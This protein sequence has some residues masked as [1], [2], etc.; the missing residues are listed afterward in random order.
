MLSD[1]FVVEALLNLSHGTVDQTTNDETIGASESQS[2]PEKSTPQVPPS[3]TVSSS[4]NMQMRRAIEIVQRYHMRGKVLPHQSA[5]RQNDPVLEQE[6][7]DAQKLSK[8]RQSVKAN[9][10]MECS[11]AVRDFLDREIVGWRDDVNS[12]KGMNRA[13][14]MQKARE[15]VERYHQRGNELPRKLA[16]RRHP[17]REQEYKDAQKLTKWKQTLKGNGNSKYNCPDEIRDYLDKEMP[18]WRDEVREKNCFPMQFAKDIVRRYHERGGVLPR[19]KIDHRK[20][21]EVTQ[22]SSDGNGT[23]TTTVYRQAT[24]EESQQEYKDARKLHKWRQTLK[25]NGNGHNCSDE[26]RD[27]LDRELVNWREPSKAKNSSLQNYVSRKSRDVNGSSKMSGRSSKSSS[28]GGL[29][30]DSSGGVDER[31]GNAARGEPGSFVASLLSTSS[32]TDIQ[33]TECS[34]SKHHVKAERAAE[35][36]EGGDCGSEDEGTTTHSDR[37]SPA[38]SYAVP[39]NPSLSAL[40]EETHVEITASIQTEND[41]CRKRARSLSGEVLAGGM[42]GGTKQPRS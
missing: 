24:H 23:I 15:I 18:R 22:P 12:R 21:Y 1:T 9:K 7:L 19:Q 35:V 20:A 16:D 25:G 8:W 38:P 26:I 36:G 32:S 14:Q 40:Q 30:S 29:D 13:V 28:V 17:D 31:A 41:V 10:K 34:L 6:H 27:F 39:L 5:D 4:S 3:S 42:S 37:S 33:E 2:L 11:D